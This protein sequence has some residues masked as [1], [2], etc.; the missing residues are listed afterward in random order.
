M[1]VVIVGAGAIGTLYGG[2]LIAGGVDVSFVARGAQLNAL[3][4]GGLTIRGDRGEFRANSLAVEDDPSRL[5]PAEAVILA[6]KLYDLR[7]AAGIAARCLAENG[8][9]VGLQNGITAFGVLRETFS[10]AQVMVGPVYSAASQVAPG[11]VDYAGARHLAVIGSPDD[12]AHSA[13]AGLVE[14][15]RRAGVEAR[16]S[17]DIE[18]V[19]WMKFLGFATNAALTCLSRQPAGVVYRDPDLLDLARRAIGEIV[20]LAEPEG[21]ALAEDA[22]AATIQLLQSFPPDMVASMRQDL[23]AG[24]RLELDEIT[25]TIVRLGI[26]HGIP[27]P[28][29]ATAYACLKPY[30]DGTPSS[31]RSAANAS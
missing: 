30:R 10:A 13:A 21:V 3:R 11:V 8:L 17:D 1:H 12:G 22:E 24:R 6:V 27:T 18:R 29:H 20:A 26:K 2:W 5:R 16:I 4:A 7:G 19:L 14:G 23:D 28:V 25:G 9:V 31:P 15:W